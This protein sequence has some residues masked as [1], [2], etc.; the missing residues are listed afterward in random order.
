MSFSIYW[1]SNSIGN[2]MASSLLTENRMDNRLSSLRT[3]FSNWRP[4]EDQINNWANHLLVVFFFALPALIDVRRSALFLIL[5]L[6]VMRGRWTGHIKKAL[7]DP[8]ALAFALYFL[9]HVIWLVGTDDWDYAK[10][11]L[12]DAA[13][14]LYP[15]LFAGFID[16]R[17]VPR[18]LWA[19]FL[20]MTVSIAWSFGISL[21]LVR[22]A[23]PEGRPL[24]PTPA[25]H[26]THYGFLLAV[27]AA[28]ALHGALNREMKRWPR[29]ALTLIFL[30][31]SINVFIAEGRTGYVLYAVLVVLVLTLRFGRR[32]KVAAPA[33]ILALAMVMLAAY[34]VS[35]TFR[36]RVDRTMESVELLA[37]KGNYD[38]A[39]GWRT[40]I[41]VYSWPLIRKTW[42]SGLGTAD[43]RQA[44]IDA[45]HL[46][47]VEISGD[48]HR[49]QHVHNEYLS[50]LLQFGIVGLLVFANLL[51]Q[52]WR[53]KKARPN[54]HILAILAVAVG[55]FSLADVFVIG[56]AALHT[57]AAMA[58]L[59]LKGYETSVPRFQNLDLRQ[60]GM[61]VMVT[62]AF[63][64]LSLAG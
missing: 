18:M 43:D 58:S 56:L 40:A 8:V 5:V 16:R 36:S 44:V 57:T 42:V 20:G 64:A 14:L 26:H 7:Q 22:A 45:I 32:A 54:G 11:V 17:F 21:E 2:N 34:H 15:V 53:G 9:V 55:L 10:K 29:T 49:L 59:A 33:G 41:L 39:I 13:F 60:A 25:W 3:R 63:L 6:F 61:Y 51:V 12:H 31:A 27:A 38:T 46:S 1:Y 37:S 4:Q 52:L 23:V 19:F 50:A 30:G 24:D 47:N 35:E 48:I 62:A 28:I